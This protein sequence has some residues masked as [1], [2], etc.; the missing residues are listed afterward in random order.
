MTYNAAL[1]VERSALTVP[2]HLAVI[3]VDRSWTYKELDEYAQQIARGL[4]KAGLSAGSHVALI[5]AT[6]GHYVAAHFGIL[7]AGMVAVP[8]NIRLR[9]HQIANLLD[10]ADVQACLVPDLPAAGLAE[11]ALS[12]IA[13]S[14]KCVVAWVQAPSIPAPTDDRIRRWQELIE[15]LDHPF[16][17]VSVAP[18][19]LAILS[20]TSGTTGHPR[21]AMLSHESELYCAPVF[22]NGWGVGST[23][24]VVATVGLFTGYGRVALLNAGLAGSVTFAFLP[25]FD[26]VQVVD[27]MRRVN[28]TGFVG[29]PAMFYELRRAHQ[30]ARVDLRSL[31]PYWR[32]IMYGGAPMR[33]D[34]REFFGQDLGLS[35]VQGYGLT[36]CGGIAQSPT[37]ARPSPLIPDPLHP[38]WPEDLQ[39]V[40]S[41]GAPVPV[42]ETGEV[43]M[44][45]PIIMQGYYKNPDRSAAC[46]RGDFFYTGDYAR[47]LNDGVF[48]LLGRQC[49]TINRGGYMIY[50]A[51]IEA[52]LLEHPAIQ[53]AAIKGLPD[54]RLGSEVAAYILL[55]PGAMAT[56]DAL[57]AWMKEQLASF[58]YPR[59]VILV[60]ALPMGPTGKVE[61]HLLPEPVT[62][63]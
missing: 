3:G 39:I 10:Y 44:R 16:E 23:D 62:N 6:G 22:Q 55:K 13:A 1:L 36:E 9:P 15:P 46:L 2:D 33:R 42:G 26:P 12:A 21:A 52:V 20:Y 17:T 60:D 61:K 5:A 57:K 27:T 53:N 8:I 59:H 19:A 49:D 47:R 25:A 37:D 58:Q 63:S 29:V 32:H 43:V 28:A 38:L 35:T 18:E 11:A 45:G 50:P 7:K 56:S 41:E 54:D 34:L 40:D 4:R 30:E 48:E 24:T 31:L 51:E 14:T